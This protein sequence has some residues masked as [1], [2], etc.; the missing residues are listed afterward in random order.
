MPETNSPDPATS[1]TPTP[2]P[3]STSADPTPATTSTDAAQT[4]APAADPSV[5]NAPDPEPAAPT[6]A[7]ETYA[8]FKFPDGR[9]ADKALV[10]EASALFKEANLTQDQAQKL[11]DLYMKNAQGVADHALGQFQDIQKDWSAK[12][13]AWIEANGGAKAIKTVIGRALNL[14][15]TKDDGSPDADAIGQFKFAMDF[16]GAGNNPAFVQGFTKL[17]RAYIEGRPTEGNG[18]SKFGQL[19]PGVSDRPSAAAAM[20]PHLANPPQS[21]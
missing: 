4:D 14:V 6:G 11:V 7:P 15:F 20:Y 8:E 2:S 19:P 17:A 9:T 5:L 18:P 1:V 21:G 3:S 13:N 10:D 12:S 16:T